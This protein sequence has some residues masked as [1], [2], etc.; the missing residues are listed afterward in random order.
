[1]RH[2]IWITAGALV[3]ATACAAVGTPAPQARLVGA[4]AATAGTEWRA[5]LV[6]RPAPQTAPRVTAKLGRTTIRV[7]VRGVAGGRYALRATFSQ[8]G[9]WQLSARMGNRNAS[10]GSVT[11]AASRIR[12]ASVLGIAVHPNGNLLIADGD[13]GRIVR[14]DLATGRLSVFAS[15]GLSAPTGMDVTRDGTV[16]VA[17]RHAPAVFRIRNG[18]VTRFAEYREPLDVAVDT[19]GVLFV[20]G[21]AHTVVR[22]DPDGTAARYAGTGRQGAS[23]DGG[24]ALAATFDAPHGVAVDPNGN[25]AV[26]EVGSVR[27]IDRPTNVLER[28]VGTGARQPCGEQG[29]PLRICLSA[30]RVGFAPNGTMWIADPE[31]RRLWRVAGGAARAYALGFSPFDVVARSATTVLVADNEN[32]RV[33]RFDT[34][35]GRVTTVAG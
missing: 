20:T 4:R 23:G 26:A 19:Q 13:A 21:R 6:I 34:S 15:R 16:Y 35:T 24:P 33:L 8:P 27:R 3:L 14:A 18:A 31:N 10:L 12:L 29:P 7:A 30:L 25:V 22:V 11:A 28:I 2:V 5:S 32:R 9:R 17:D 1:M